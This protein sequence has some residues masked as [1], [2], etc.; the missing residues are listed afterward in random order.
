M[1][2]RKNEGNEEFFAQIRKTIEPLAIESNNRLLKEAC[3]F[4]V[5]DSGNGQS[6]M[7]ALEK[8]RMYGYYH[9][10]LE[11]EQLLSNRLELCR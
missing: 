4:L 7:R 1:F 8:L 11:I 10:A 2:T 5:V 9:G 6:A 3:L